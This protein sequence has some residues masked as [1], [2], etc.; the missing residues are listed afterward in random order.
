M[1]HI[2]VEQLG[3]IVASVGLLL[4]LCPEPKNPEILGISAIGRHG[5]F[6][7]QPAQNR[8]SAARISLVRLN[9]RFAEG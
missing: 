7:A 9:I 1:E 2:A 6:A 5:N 8:T 4:L 3:R